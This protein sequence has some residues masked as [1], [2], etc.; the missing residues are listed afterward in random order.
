MSGVVGQFGCKH[1]PQSRAEHGVFGRQFGEQPAEQGHCGRVESL[2]LPPP[3][4]GVPADGDGELCGGLGI[5]G[6]ERSFR[7]I[8]HGAPGG[9]FLSGALQGEDQRQRD[10]V[11]LLGGCSPVTGAGPCRVDAIEL[12]PW[13]G[14]TGQQ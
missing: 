13:S 12:T 6:S 11:P 8:D 14:Q 10:L 4:Y 9:A 1:G 5:G 3:P 2:V 7:G